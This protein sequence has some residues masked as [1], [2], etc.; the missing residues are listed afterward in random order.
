MNIKDM[1]DAF[2][3]GVYDAVA[4]DKNVIILTADH[5]AFRL[6]EI[7]R[8]FPDQYLNIGISEQNMISFAGG[9]ATS[10]K[11]VYVYSINNFIAVRSLEQVSIDL[12]AMNCHVN[13]IGVGAG[14]TYSTDGPTHHGM[15]DAQAMMTLPR[16]Q[17][18]NVTDDVNSRKL[19]DLGY[20]ESGP[21]YF[22]IEKGKYD[23]LYEEDEN[24]S[25]GM[26]KIRDFDE[27]VILSTGYMTHTALKVAKRFKNVGVID[28]YR[29]KPLNYEKLSLLLKNAKN[30]VSLE[31][32]TCSGGMGEKIGFF[33]AKK[34]LYKH[35]L[36]IAVDDQ[37]CFHYGSREMLH[38]KYFIDEESVYNKMR[39][40]L[41]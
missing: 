23:R 28:L 34:G 26:K 20:Y 33:M 7:A 2:F 16:L 32:M 24:L 12:C 14:F 3:D 8:D 4:Q 31:E 21:K 40:F 22:R 15:Q 39:D 30:V 10:G 11:I 9:L 29:L 25:D 13:L 38:K 1:R 27:T 35:F 36:P 6:A 5:G 37:Y 19:A 17:V 41:R 18:Y